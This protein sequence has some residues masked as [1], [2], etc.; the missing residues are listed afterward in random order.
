MRDEIEAIAT[1]WP[2]ILLKNIGNREVIVERGFIGNVPGSFNNT[3]LS[4]LL[5]V[6]IAFGILGFN[7]S[8][9]SYSVLVLGLGLGPA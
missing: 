3:R 4:P 8:G 5:E 2:V 1:L 6:S 9:S 7:L